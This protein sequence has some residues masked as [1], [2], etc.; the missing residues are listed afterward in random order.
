[1]SSSVK[2]S[3]DVCQRA[4]S[5]LSLSYFQGRF[6]GSVVGVP[7]GTNRGL[8]GKCK[9]NYRLKLN[10]NLMSKSHIKVPSYKYAQGCL[11]VMIAGKYELK[12]SRVYG[13]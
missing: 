2:A 11:P 8:A 10:L 6:D 9:N 13:T 7:R 12:L 4:R 1:M 5:Q 3:I